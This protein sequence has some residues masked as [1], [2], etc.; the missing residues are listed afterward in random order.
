MEAKGQ[1]CLAHG[2]D[3]TLNL[4]LWVWLVRD[5]QSSLFKVYVCPNDDKIYINGWWIVL[6]FRSIYQF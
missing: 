4:V 2:A 3:G 5:W 1:V 6:H